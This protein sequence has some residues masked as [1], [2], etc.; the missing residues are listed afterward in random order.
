MSS[1]SIGITFC[2]FKGEIFLVDGFC[3]LIQPA[4]L[5]LLIGELG[6]LI[7]WF[8]TERCILIHLDFVVLFLFFP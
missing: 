6:P 3:F 1:G 8:S 5:C 7:L 2:I 4:I